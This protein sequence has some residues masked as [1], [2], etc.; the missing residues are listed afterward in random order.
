MVDPDIALTMLIADFPR[1]DR[2]D[3]ADWDCLI[4]AA[5][6][7]DWETWLGALK[8]LVLPAATLAIAWVLHQGEHVIAIPGTR[9]RTHLRELV[10]GGTLDLGADD[11][12]RI[13]EVLPVGWAHGDRYSVGQW[14]GPER[15]C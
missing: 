15:Y 13:E 10:E 5:I 11:V 14:A 3:P 7:G 2:C 6:A 12:S 8:Q 1:P 9:S 4:D